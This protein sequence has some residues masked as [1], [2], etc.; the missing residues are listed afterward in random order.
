ML[1]PFFRTIEGFQVLIEKDWISFGHKFGERVAHSRNAK[2]D[3]IAPVFVQFIDCT[4]HFWQQYPSH[5]EFNE[6]FLI[7]I[8]DN[9]Y[10][11]LFGNFLANSEKQR[12][13]LKV[14]EQ[15]VSLWTFVKANLSKFKNPMYGSDYAKYL[16]ITKHVTE[17]YGESGLIVSK[18]KLKRVYVPDYN[19]QTLSLRFWIGYYFR[20]NMGLKSRYSNQL[21]DSLQKIAEEN[22]QMQK[23]LKK[24]EKEKKQ[25]EDELRK[26]KKEREKYKKVMEQTGGP[27]ILMEESDNMVFVSFATDHSLK[28]PSKYMDHEVE[29]K[30][31][32]S[33]I[34]CIV[35]DYFK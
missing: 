29:I 22:V 13:E 17:K 35:Q 24:E 33:K 9:L 32:S 4:W 26:L 14:Q 6:L 34:P 1:D 16:A 18:K 19:I 15:T 28:E 20:Y 21:Q 12:W 25:L 23:R 3:E 10:S 2:P 30:V 27:A 11:C 31:T 8:L 5:F 7:T